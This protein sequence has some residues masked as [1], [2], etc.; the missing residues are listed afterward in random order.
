MADR[1]IRGDRFPRS[2]PEPEPSSRHLYAGHH[3]GS[4]QGFPQAAPEVTTLLGF[5][6]VSTLSTRHQWFTHVRLLGSYLTHCSCALSATLTTSALDRRSVQWFEASP[7]R[8]AS[9]GQPPSLAQPASVESD[10]L[11]RSLLQPSWRTVVRVPQVP[12]ATIRRIGQ[13]D[14]GK[15]LSLLTQ[16][17][18]F[19]WTACPFEVA[20]L[21]T[22]AVVCGLC[23]RR[24]P[25]LNVGKRSVSTN[26]SSRSR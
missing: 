13:V 3:L 17:S 2:T 22:E 23:C 10:L 4:R 21:R 25:R 18:C 12:E 26:R 19:R 9:E 24:A 11:H 6:V 1:H 20:R 14:R 15:P 8:A 7:C 16:N 5:D